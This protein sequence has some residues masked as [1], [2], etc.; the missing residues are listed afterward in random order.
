M[1]NN[2]DGMGDKSLSIMDVEAY[3]KDNVLLENEKVLWRGRSR[4]SVKLKH[5]LDTSTKLKK[6]LW[7][8]IT[9][10]SGLVFF[11]IFSTISFREE[12]IVIPVI[13]LSIPAFP[14]FLGVNFLYLKPK[15][16]LL[17]MNNIYYG[18]TNKRIL[19]MEFAN[20]ITISPLLYEEID[21]Y[22]RI[23][24]LGDLS[25]IFLKAPE[26]NLAQLWI[27]LWVKQEPIGLYYIQDGK[28]AAKIIQ[29]YLA[30]G[31]G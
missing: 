1:C 8:I 24:F 3:V 18:L 2:S 29:Q 9:I 21:S 14:C 25:T 15:K 16:K 10:V 30:S 19:I 22:G 17:G 13:V 12:G 7:Y 11:A 5:I 26:E 27:R 6:W 20:E 28:N 31:S 23:D 4:P